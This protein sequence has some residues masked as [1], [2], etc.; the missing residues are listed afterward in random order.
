MRKRL[1]EILN[2]NSL[3]DAFMIIVI[4]VSLIPLAMNSQ[5]PVFHYLDMVTVTIF[6]ADYIARW[7]T[8]D[9]TSM[10]HKAVAFV[11]YPIRAMAIIDFMSIMPSLVFINPVF[12]TLRI[13]RLIR[14]LRVLRLFRYSKNIQI[15]VRVLEKQRQSLV[16]VGCFAVGYILTSAIVMF[17]VEPKTFNNFFDAVYWA[18][19]SLT[20]VGYGDIFAT[21]TIGKLITMVS[22]LMGIAVVALP[23]GIITAGYLDEINSNGSDQ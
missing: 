1:N 16:T 18:T 9:I 5:S 3:Y 8:A 23:A 12:K 17:Q 15:I 4:L 7:L 20:T 19:I 22:A 2:N 6:I 11:S 21:S 13:L 14:A 10:H